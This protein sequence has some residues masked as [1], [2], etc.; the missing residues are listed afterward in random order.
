M[1]FFFI[2]KNENNIT[3]YYLVIFLYLLYLKEFC[4][5]ITYKSSFSLEKNFEYGYNNLVDRRGY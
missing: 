5:E 3:F 4:T 1:Y 2:N